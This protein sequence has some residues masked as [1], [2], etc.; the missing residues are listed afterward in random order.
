MST[1]HSTLAERIRAQAEGLYPT[2]AAA[3]LI[4]EALSGRLLEKLDPAVHEVP[5]RG[6]AYID[7]DH[8]L[9]LAAPFSSGERRIINLAASLFTGQHPI[10]AQDTFTGLDNGNS[11]VALEAIAHSLNYPVRWARQ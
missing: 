11:R 2:E 10:D 9:D 1:N 3:H 6:F 5:E 8:A 4:T 7:W